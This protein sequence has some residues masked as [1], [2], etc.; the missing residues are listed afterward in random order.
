MSFSSASSMFCSA[1]CAWCVFACSPSSVCCSVC[2]SCVYES[3]I[4]CSCV[5][6]VLVSCVDIKDICSTPISWGVLACVSH[7]LTLLSS[8]SSFFSVSCCFSSSSFCLSCFSSSFSLPA[9][10][11]ALRFAAADVV[12]VV[13]VFFCVRLSVRITGGVCLLV[14]RSCIV[15]AV[16]ACVWE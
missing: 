7:P 9:C 2:V 8:S 11:L 15:V 6:C 10:V 14:P 4:S 5:S 16:V 3:C 13:A 12:V 1:S